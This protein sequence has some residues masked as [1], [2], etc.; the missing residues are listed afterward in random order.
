MSPLAL[1]NCTSRHLTHR[2]RQ[3]NISKADHPAA[4][5]GLAGLAGLMG[6]TEKGS[7]PQVDM[8]DVSSSSAKRSYHHTI[9]SCDQHHLYSHTYLYVWRNTLKDAE[10]WLSDYP[11]MNP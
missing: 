11:P 2:A 3:C 9:S 7:L 10:R 1:L 5:A 6:T 8:S 4:L